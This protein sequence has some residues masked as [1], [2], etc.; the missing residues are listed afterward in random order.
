MSS[1]GVE[2]DAVM[3]AAIRR[4]PRDLST[5]R[6]AKLME[7]LRNGATVGTAQAHS[8]WRGLLQRSQADSYQLGVMLSHGSSSLAE[9]QSRLAEAEAAG[10]VPHRSAFNALLSRMQIDGRDAAEIEGV[11]GT[12]E[13]AKLPRDDEQEALTRSI[14]AIDSARLSAMR[15]AELTRRVRRGATDAYAR[16]SAWALFCGLCERGQV[17]SYQVRAMRR[18]ADELARGNCVLS[19][20]ARSHAYLA[21]YERAARQTATRWHSHVDVR[22]PRG[23]QDAA[24]AS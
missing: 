14:L 15:T 16:T 6:T 5:M 23:Q 11:L 4:S 8:L 18:A 10:L 12:M 2:P 19:P 9:M 21:T 3:Q 1:L 20:T 7:L 24:A 22:R 17:D 13:G